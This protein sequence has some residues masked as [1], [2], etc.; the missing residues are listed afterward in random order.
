MNK[1]GL[2]DTQPVTPSVASS[3]TFHKRK[4]LPP[5]LSKT[6]KKLLQDIRCYIDE[7]KKKI[8]CTEEY[9]SHR[10]SVFRFVPLRIV[11]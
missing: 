11:P 4:I 1:S 7:E 5:I 9:S 3:Y 10:F 2:T 6:D 8:S